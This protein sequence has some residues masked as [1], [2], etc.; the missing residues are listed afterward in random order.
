MSLLAEC[1]L[2]DGIFQFDKVERFHNVVAK[3]CCQTL[4]NIRLGP[5]S[6][7]SDSGGLGIFFEGMQDLDP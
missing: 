3:T 7:Q 5:E 6:T 1:N 2:L 4:F